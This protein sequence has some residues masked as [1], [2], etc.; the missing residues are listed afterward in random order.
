VT[1][2]LDVPDVSYARSGDVAIAYQVV[3]E[4]PHDLVLV[5]FHACIFTLWQ[6]P[7]FGEFAAGLVRQRRLIVIN[8]RG[9]GLSDRPRGFT[10]ESR[11]DDVRAVMDAVAS[12]R[13]AVLGTIRGTREL[14]L[15]LCARIH[16]G[17]CELVEGKPAGLSVHVGAR[18]AAEARPNEVLV[19]SAIKDLVAGSGMGFSERAPLSSRACP[20]TGRFT[21][22]QTEVPLVGDKLTGPGGG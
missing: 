2:R 11:M 13:A 3:G 8:P 12:R 20:G 17:E 14:G 4:G 9:M 7:G 10:V 1:W 16:T 6:Q 5:P 22:W 15:A 19:S 21:R 18:V